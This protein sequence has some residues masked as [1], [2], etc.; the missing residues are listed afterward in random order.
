[1]ASVFTRIINGELPGRIVYSDEHAVAFLTIAPI[2]VGHT[3]VVPRAEV[4]HWIDV[5]DDLLRNCWSAART[6][7][8][9][10]DTAFKPRRV[11]ALLAGLEVP[12]MHI[13][14]LPIESESEIDFRLA[15]RSPDPAVMDDAAERIRAALG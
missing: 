13:H 3:L 6:V 9:A 5:P 14:V 7:G 8:R 12:H 15:N 11:A 10:I 1:M 4:D 2:T